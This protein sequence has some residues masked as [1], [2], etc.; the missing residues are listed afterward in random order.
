MK[1]NNYFSK[2]RK[3]QRKKLKMYNSLCSIKWNKK[4]KT[5][6]KRRNCMELMLMNGNYT[7]Q[8]AT[9]KKNTRERWSSS[10]YLLW[11]NDN[12]HLETQLCLFLHLVSFTNEYFINNLI[13]YRRLLFFQSHLISLIIWSI[14]SILICFIMDAVDFSHFLRSPFFMIIEIQQHYVCQK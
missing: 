14:L 3:I 9:D 7:S 2:T 12:I 10:D 6:I 1:Y 4:K 13:E 5:D 11:D 8:S